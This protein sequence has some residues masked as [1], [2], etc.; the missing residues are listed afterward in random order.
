M[1]QVLTILIAAGLAVL[2][3]QLLSQTNHPR[4]VPPVRSIAAAPTM[5]FLDASIVPNTQSESHLRTEPDQPGPDEEDDVEIQ[6][7]VTRIDSLFVAEAFDPY[8]SRNEQINLRESLDTS[9]ST[10]SRLESIEC[11]E[12]MCRVQLE[13]S[14]ETAHEETEQRFLRSTRDMDGFADVSPGQD[15]S[16]HVTYFLMRAGHQLPPVQ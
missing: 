11:R 16:L 8:W 2:V 7:Y 13:H 9:L 1:K 5:T 15:G 14:D 12:T 4:P 10:S 3:Q 6:E